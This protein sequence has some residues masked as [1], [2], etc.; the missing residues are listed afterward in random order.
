MVLLAP[1]E[2]DVS[3]S[4]EFRDSVASLLATGVR[5]IVIDMAPVRFIDSS[6]IGALIA[7]AKRAQALGI[8]LRLRN[9]G[10]RPEMTLRMSGAINV[11]S[12][13]D[14]DVSCGE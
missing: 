3:S 9:L 14:E 13:D 8:D 1:D 5:R 11:L 6:G 4:S 2:L 7:L 10:E 12:I